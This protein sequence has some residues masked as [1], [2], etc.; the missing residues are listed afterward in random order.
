MKLLVLDGNSIINRAFYGIKLLTTK[1]GRYTNALVGFMNILLKLQTEEQPDEIAIAF[2]LKSPTFRHKMYDGYKAQRKGMPEELAAQM[3]LLKELLTLLGYQIVT[4][5]GWEADDILG[6]LAAACAA[7]GD[8]CVLATGDRDSL[9]LVDDKTRVLL[10]STQMGKSVTLQMDEAAVREKYGV[11]PAQLIDVKSLM[12]D[13]S[14]NIPGVAGIGEKTASTLISTFGSLE[15][16]YEH[17]DDPRIKKGVRE[18]LERDK[19]QAEMSRTLATI[20]RHAPVETEPGTYRRCASDVQGVRTMLTGLEMYQTLSKLSLDETPEQ[21]GFGDVSD[22]TTPRIAA[23]PLEGHALQGLVYLLPQNTAGAYTGE[24]TVLLVQGEVVYSATMQTPALLDLLDNAEIEKQCFD[25]KPLHRAA[26]AAGRNVK[27]L[28]FDAKLAAYLLQPS[29]SE[30]SVERLAGEHCLAPAFACETPA[31]ALLP[32][33]CD[34]LRTA[35]DAQGMHDL[36][37][38]I[39]LPLCEVLADMEHQGILVNEEGI[40]AFGVELQAALTEQLNAIYEMVGYEFNVNSPKQLGKA[41]FEDLHLPTGKKTKSGWSTNAET[42]EGLRNRAPVVDHILQY[43]TYQKLNSTY[44][45]GLLKVI[46]EDGRIH[47]TFNQTET[48][49]GRISSGEPNLQN[50]PVRTQLGSRFRKYF[51]AAKGCTL[52]DADYSQ[53]ELRILAH[54]AGDE[55]MRE[56]FE[57][58]QD[59]HRTT[60]AKVHG[61]APEDVTPALRS[62]AKAV[63]FGIVY[64]IGAFSLS[65]DIGVSVKEADA[66][67]KTYLGNFPSVKH[68]MDE[69]IAKGRENGYVTTL[70]GR[71]RTLPE[72]ASSNFNLRALGERMAMNTP[73]QGTAADIIKLAMVRVHRRLAAEGLRAKLILQVHDE[74]IVECPADEQERAAAIL[75]EEMR[76]AASLSVPLSADVNSGETWYDAK[77]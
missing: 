57:S 20:D 1:D 17:L 49:T 21:L 16:V 76:G 73:I 62:S 25:A 46:G 2:D 58:G 35:C 42:L 47:S 19:E 50:I 7:R 74:L 38:D 26:L 52:L 72:L 37:C 39:E 10:A 51:I 44:V 65:K 9:Q 24:E 13:A 28:T 70:Y 18:K 8:T 6:T 69:T 66:F 4:C 15:S 56:A 23:V 61:I 40:R 14:D 43:R 67:I 53:I 54:I 48:R 30:Y 41:L 75:G 55:T 45:E 33:L 63:N 36:L 29:T 12:G 34:A 27:N 3:P 31:A 64:G 59:I 11:S 22:D 5:E 32:A 60:A 68:Y 71:R 77:G